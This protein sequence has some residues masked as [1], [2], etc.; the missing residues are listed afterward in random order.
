MAGYIGSKTVNLSTTGADIAGD[1]DVSGALDVGGAFTSQGIDDNANATAITIDSSE[2]VGIGVTPS[3]W[4]SGQGSIQ[5]KDGGLS[6]WSNGALNGYIYSNAYYDGTNN[7][8]IN[9]GSA[10]S[11]A[12]N[13]ATG[14]HVWF[15]APSGTAGNAVSFTEAMRID[16]AGRVTTPSQPHIHGMPNNSSGSGIANVFYTAYSRNTLSF[17]NSRVT[18]PVA[19]AYLINFNTISDS[20]TGRVDANILVNGTNI[21]SALS[22]DNGQGFHQKSLSAV[23]NLS[24]NDYI[25]VS[26]ADWYNSGITSYDRWKTLSITLVG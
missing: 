5:F 16:A 18:V 15:T 12:I 26:N 3:A 7:R 19:G 4:A 17:S 13:N 24:A 22:E 25:Q 9:N 21:L 23:V 8:Y 11:Y 20:S 1:A 6:A 14:A 2:N 10:G